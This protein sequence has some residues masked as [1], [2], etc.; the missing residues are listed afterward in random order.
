[1]TI[2]TALILPRD[3]ITAKPVEHYLEQFNF[4]ISTGLKIILFLDR[5][6]EGKVPDH[7]NITIVYTSIFE[8]W[9]WN[10][11][12][13]ETYR[14]PV[15]EARD[16][17][18]YSI[19]INSK[20]EFLSKALEM[21]HDEVMW[22]DFGVSHVIK[23]REAVKKRL[24]DIKPVEGI[25]LPGCWE[26]KGDIMDY[27]N[28]RFSGGFILGDRSSL[29]KFWEDSKIALERVKPWVTWEVNIWA[30]M[31]VHMGYQFKWYYGN[32]DDGLILN[33]PQNIEIKEDEQSLTLV[34]SFFLRDYI[35]NEEDL[36]KYYNWAKDLLS[37][38][39]PFHIF[40]DSKCYDYFKD[41][42]EGKENLTRWEILDTESLPLMGSLSKI[43]FFVN[44]RRYTPDVRWSPHYMV[45]TNSKFT[46]VNKAAQD[47]YFNS[48]YFA[49]VDF[50]I[51]KTGV[52]KD[53]VVSVLEGRVDKFRMGLL[54][55]HSKEFSNNY[56]E[57]FMFGRP[58]TIGGFWMASRQNILE[59]TDLCI[60]KYW[61]LVDSGYGHA[62]EQTLYLVWLHN[63]D[64]FDPYAGDYH[65]IFDNFYGVR[66]LSN[67]YRVIST[68]RES[69][70]PELAAKFEAQ[71]KNFN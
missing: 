21:T 62:D 28:W 36:K 5:R 55:V 13:S 45:L 12:G 58:V 33:L 3:G 39:K 56:P 47:N 15:R 57:F 61:E 8:T 10:N 34:T 31:E 40:I 6:L 7:P 71:I 30:W 11:L 17:L 42:R 25:Y 60:Q 49:W 52:T 1:M 64:L 27:A 37:I 68:C 66:N 24:Q 35:N 2:V 16:T 4:L 69:G 14:I 53:K 19:I 59:V 67:L 44:S 20:L 50:G 22:V 9:Y 26:N 38:N 43:E 48:N 41:L 18:D 63:P 54:G 46:F 51:F 32:H 65:T 70:F 29:K 23:D